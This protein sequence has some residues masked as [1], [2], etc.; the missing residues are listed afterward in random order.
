M[1][2]SII[3]D[4]KQITKQHAFTLVELLVVISIIAL[5]VSIL[6]PALAK[7]RSQ[8][9]G[10]VCANNLRQFGL[11][12]ILYAMEEDDHLPLAQNDEAS[13]D[14]EHY[15]SLTGEP[16]IRPGILWHG[17][18][19]P[20][21]IQQCPGYRG[22]SSTTDPEDHTGYNYNRSFIG[23]P[24]N[25]TPKLASIKQASTCPLFGEGQLNNGH[26]NK[27]MRS[28]VK[29]VND[30]MQRDRSGG[31]PLR[32]GGAQG[33]RHSQASFVVYADGHARGVTHLFIGRDYD[34]VVSF[35]IMAAH[36]N[37]ETGTLGFLSD[38]NSGY[39]LK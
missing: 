30:Q 8:A 22:D 39:D 9:Q 17:E 1:S 12:A 23:E 20:S 18:K 29:N 26:A 4:K 28:P 31:Y 27:Y 37:F 16:L 15:T 36:D 38:D 33:I 32:Y 10:V 34:V 6:M 5:L 35:G 14:F 3:N 21:E 7:G 13:W 24:G 2:L 11:A 19:V 25:P